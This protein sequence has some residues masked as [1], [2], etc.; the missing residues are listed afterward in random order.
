MKYMVKALWFISLAMLPGIASALIV[1]EDILPSSTGSIVLGEWNKNFDHG[2]EIADSQNI[3]MVVFYGGLSCGACESLQK[4]CLTEEFLTWQAKKKIVFIFT[5]DNTRGD[6]AGFAKPTIGEKGFPYIAIYWNRDGKKPAK[7]SDY[8]I[9]FAGR[10]GNMPAKGGTLASQLIR[11]ID[12][13]AGA[14]PYAGGEFAVPGSGSDYARLELE[15][16]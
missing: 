2:R 11:S 7:N 10:D 12:S 15:E 4:A 1:P 8:Y 5:K 14:Y 16:G 13:I 6:A 3:P 9:A